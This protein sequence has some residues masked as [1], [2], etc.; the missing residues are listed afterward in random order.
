MSRNARIIFLSEISLVVNEKGG[1]LV[2]SVLLEQ[3][4]Q[5]IFKNARST[6]RNIG[7]D[8]YNVSDDRASL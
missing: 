2:N 4:F 7:L 3:T 8:A 6:E 1:N 5:K